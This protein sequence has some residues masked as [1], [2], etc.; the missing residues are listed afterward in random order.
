[1]SVRILKLNEIESLQ[2]RNEI[3]KGCD[4]WLLKRL[5]PRKLQRKRKKKK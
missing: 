5:Q 4:L 3:W 2:L 1:M